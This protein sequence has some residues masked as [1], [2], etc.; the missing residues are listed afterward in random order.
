[1]KDLKSKSNSLADKKIALCLTGSIAVV[2]SVK[3]SR[4]LRRLGAS[5]TAYMS[6]SAQDILNPS[7]MEF[8]TGEKPVTSLSGALE[9]LGKFDLII[10]APAT[11]NTISKLANGIA[12]NAVT[13]L[14]LSSSCE[15]IIAPSMH[16]EMIDNPILRKNLDLLK[17][18]YLISEPIFEEG[19]AKMA[20]FKDIVEDAVY[21]LSKKDFAGKKVVV[22]AGPTFESIDPVRIITNRSSGKMGL[23][24][25]REARLRGAQVTLI[26]GPMSIKPHKG[27]KNIS[28]ESAVDLE[29]ALTEINDYD[30]FIGA[31]AVS[32]F[33]T[34]RRDKKIDSSSGVIDLKLEPIPKL[35]SQVKKNAVRVGFKAEHNVSDKELIASGQQLLHKYTLDPVVANDVSK[36]VFGSDE[37]KVILISPRKIVKLKRML[38]VEVA[39]EIFDA[40]VRM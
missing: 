27:I 36:K 15:I 17:Q 21:A 32:D 2:E 39:R 31:A 37:N 26:S 19:S 35:I 11:A 38:K 3:I 1:M 14:V 18:R 22:T 20:A 33:K 16:G 9:H 30:I 8:A 25:A 6:R 5:V 29:K 12:D 40:L 24:L 13:T 4:E 7:A 34:V 28:V 10:I 23:A